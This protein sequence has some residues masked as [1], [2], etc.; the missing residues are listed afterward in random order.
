MHGQEKIRVPLSF[1]PIGIIL[2][3]FTHIIS[4]LDAIGLSIVCLIVFYQIQSLSYLSGM[5]VPTTKA[6]NLQW[7]I[8]DTA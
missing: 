2:S 1:V 5:H 3:N 6:F 4:I 7:I 8:P